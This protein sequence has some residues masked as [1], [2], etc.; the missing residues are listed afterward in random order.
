M[1]VVITYSEYI[2][3]ASQREGRQGAVTHTPENDGNEETNGI[4]RHGRRQE[5]DS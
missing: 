5:H 1:G 4:G 2:G 3:R